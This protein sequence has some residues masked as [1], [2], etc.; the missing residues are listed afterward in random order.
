MVLS[1]NEIEERMIVVRGQM[2]LLDKD[3]AVLYGV[4]TKHV[5]QAVKN[6]PSK[7]PE[8]YVLELND[9]E[10]SQVKTF[11]LSARSHYN[12]KVF[13]EKGLYML[14]TILKGAVATEATINIIETY[15]KLKRLG[16]VIKGA[17]STPDEEKK[18][19]L[20]QRAGE[21]ISDLATDAMEITEDEFTMELNLVAVKLSRKVKRHKRPLSND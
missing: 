11:D 14:A 4:E 20:V 2:V 3:V 1:R 9:D 13:T 16:R 8:G 21:I 18:K 7:F 15:S 10:M 17:A 6:N 19:S 12:A 5:N